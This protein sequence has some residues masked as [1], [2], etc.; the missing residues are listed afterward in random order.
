MD[1]PD[2]S[3]WD[4]TTCKLA[5]CQHPQCWATIRRIERGH[6]RIL[7]PPCKTTLNDEDKLPVLTIVNMTDSC[8]QAKGLAHRHL[9]GFTFTKPSSSLCPGSKFDSKFQGRPRKD[10]PDKDLIDRTD[11]SPKVNHRLEK[12][13]VLNLNETQLP[14]PQDVRNMVVIWIPEQSETHVSPAEK[15]HILPSQ[16]W[17]KRRMKSTVKDR[18]LYGKQK[19]ETLLGPPG[20]VVPPPSPAHFIEQLNAESIPFWNQLDRLPQ[21]LLKDLLPGEGKTMPSLEMKTQLAMMKKKA[22][23]ERSRPDSA[24]S[25]WMFLS[26]QRLALQRPALRYPKHLKKF[27]YNPNTEGHKKQQQWQQKEQQRKVK[28]PP[29]KQEAKKKSKSDLGSQDILHK[30]SGAVVSGPRYG[31]RTLLSRKSDKKQPQR[32]K[33]EGPTSKK[34]STRRPQMEYSENYLDS[35]PDKDDPELSKTEPSNKDIGA[36]ESQDRSSEDLSDD[37]SERRWN[38]ELK[39]LRILQ[40]TDDEDEENQL[41]GSESEE[42]FKTSQDSLMRERDAWNPEDSDLGHRDRKERG[43]LLPGAFT[44]T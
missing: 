24:I 16:D 44:R 8:I 7:A 33:P 40:A 42:S 4:E 38:P 32:A 1:L 34:C 20:V 18:F 31:Q 36:Q 29:K 2:E 25:A 19:T 13:S 10:L 14:S 35:F 26:I 43:L 15:K 21:D 28:T 41:S 22:P 30:R 6:P 9:S 5:I 11:R 3:Q 12:L 23:L 27:Y 39:L 37:S 17:M